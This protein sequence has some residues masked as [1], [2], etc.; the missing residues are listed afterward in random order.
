MYPGGTYDE[1]ERW[2]RNFLGSHAKRVHPRLEA[3]VDT[4]GARGGLS[5][6]VRLRLGRR[7]STVLELD[8]AEVAAQRGSLAW[9]A[10]LAERTRAL[11][12]ELVA[13]AGAPDVQAG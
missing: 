3:E 2:L 8:Y 4:A 5:Y 9:C 7:R 6:G 11:A 10:A 13:G 1:V 12:R